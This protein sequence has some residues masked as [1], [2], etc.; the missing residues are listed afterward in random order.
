[1]SKAFTT[2]LV[3]L[4]LVLA[5]PSFAQEHSGTITDAETGDALIGANV[6][7]AG[8]SIGASTDADGRFSFQY[9]DDQDYTVV[10]SFVGYRTAEREISMESN[11]TDLN[12]ELATDP[13][14]TDEIVV[15]GIASRTSKAVAEVAVARVNMTEI[16]DRQSYTSLSQMMLGKVSGVSL[17]SADGLLGAPFR[18]Q[19][20]SG[21][22]LHGSAQPI[23]VIDGVRTQQDRFEPFSGEYNQ[24]ANI[25]T[26]NNLNA[27]E[28]ESIEML[29]GPA[30]AA[31][32]GTDGANGVILITTKKGTLGT[33]TGTRNYSINYKATLGYNG[34]ERQ[35]TENDVR[36]YNELND[37]FRKGAIQKNNLNISGGTDRMRYF[38][39]FDKSL[40]KAHIPRNSEART[41]YRV[42]IDAYPNDKIDVNVAAGYFTGLN[43]LNGGREFA[44]ARRRR[45]PFDGT[46]PRATP[47]FYDITQEHLFTNQLTASANVNY[48]PFLD[49]IQNLRGLS[50]QFTV[51]INDRDD[52]ST[53]FRQPSERFEQIGERSKNVQSIVNTTYT[54]NMRYDYNFW[55]ITSSASAGMQLYDNKKNAF[56][57]VSEEFVTELIS[58]LGA[59]DVRTR[60]SERD[61]HERKAGIFTEHS[62]SYENTYFWSAMLRRDYTS[63]LKVGHESIYY[64]RFSASVRLD[65]FDAVP[66]AFGLLKFRAAYGE[67]G[68]L[69]GRS[70]AIP[71][72]YG[73]T[74][75]PYGVG[76][77]L[78]GIGN[79]DI[80]PE[81]VREIEV[82]IDAEYRNFLSVDFTY[83]YSKSNNAIFGVTQ[84]PSYGTGGRRF[85][86]NIGEI[87]GFGIESQTSLFFSGQRL[88]GWSFNLTNIVNWSG[89][90]V[91]SIGGSNPLIDHG[92]W[93]IW[94]GYERGFARPVK[95]QEA[96]FTEAGDPATNT[97]AAGA[98][99]YADFTKVGQRTAADGR[100]DVGHQFP[101]WTGSFSSSIS[102]GNF[103]A[104]GM[105]EWKYNFWLLND[106]LI[107]DTGPREDG[108]GSNILKFDLVREKL[109]IEE[110]GLVP[111]S[112]ELA[113][114]TPEYIS[115]ANW[116]ARWGDQTDQ[117]SLRRSDFLKFKEL[118]IS[119]KADTLIPKLGL[120]NYINGL[121]FGFNATNLWMLHHDSF[122]GL[123]SVETVRGIL[124]NIPDNVS[125]RQAV[126]PMKSIS[127]FTRITL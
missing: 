23:I 91:I 49:G 118:A 15:T 96:V 120:Q 89:N 24:L 81:R 74:L 38:A 102:L 80:E 114:G 54:G 25:T 40:N 50:L 122:N 41:N 61:F 76:A 13:F 6:L 52:R 127:F 72:L 59:G 33:G 101:P 98:G 119:Y 121:T 82:G 58:T 1:M 32:Y 35:Y 7:I 34:Q 116:W 85:N 71:Q 92:T 109:Q 105:F 66:D 8:K 47:E 64:P 112:E 43:E 90:E 78:S 42:N 39:S 103:S 95:G 117:N 111:E 2:G 87:K 68:I 115:H 113:P 27:E 46:R 56:N 84:T 107:D 31:S 10:V 51:G 28:I 123:T 104:Y 57:G 83:Y 70:D 69:P 16:A 99:Y 100:E 108:L 110:F 14:G 65:R 44:Q 19:T 60:L 12:F 18:F 86:A 26:I 124:E 11:T 79:I 48:R 55:G 67:T 20:R 93:T 94:P 77:R 126:P 9:T 88:G 17:I 29:K 53:Y 45:N 36:S 73:S 125:S 62:F 22:G 21:G 97:H 37:F 63:S 106:T 75:S 3:F 4:I 5:L 30:G